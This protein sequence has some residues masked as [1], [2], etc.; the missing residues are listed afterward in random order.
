MLGKSSK[1]KKRICLHNSVLKGEN[2]IKSDI[3]YTSSY[4]VSNFK[5]KVPKNVLKDD[6]FKNCCHRDTLNESSATLY[7]FEKQ[8]FLCIRLAS[9]CFNK[10]SSQFTITKFETKFETKINLSRNYH[11]QCP[12]ILYLQNIFAVQILNSN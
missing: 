12:K 11:S 4:N 10:M 7:G 3:N 2:D 1:W 8:V 5:E 6:N 9:I